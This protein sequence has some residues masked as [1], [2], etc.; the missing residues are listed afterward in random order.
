MKTTTEINKHCRPKADAGSDTSARS[1][2]Q[3]RIAPMLVG[4]LTAIV[5]AYMVIVNESV[6]IVRLFIR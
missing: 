2:L 5:S 4:I 6:F 1:L 3:N